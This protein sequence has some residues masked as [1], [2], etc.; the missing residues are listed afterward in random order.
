MALLNASQYGKLGD[1]SSSQQRR[2]PGKFHS[3][4][5]TG[6]SRE[7]QE[8][9][10]FQVMSD[11]DKGIYL[12]QNESEVLF[13]PYFIKRI[14][15]KYTESLNQKNEKYSKLVAFGWADDIPK[16]DDD[17]KY[18]YIIAGLLLDK[19]GQAMKHE[20]DIEDAGIKVGD[21]VLCYFSCGG[22]KFNGAMKFIDHISDK[23]KDLP[24]LSDSPEFERTV[25]YPRRFICKV[26]K[27]I[28]PSKHGDKMVFDFAVATQLPD[29]VVGKVMDS[30]MG[31]LPEFEKQFDKTAFVRGGTASSVSTSVDSDA[32]TFTEAPDPVPESDIVTDDDFD[33]GI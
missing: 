8:I 21:P 15:T 32:P 22:M 20:I 4:F 24:P 30:A 33:L 1:V 27:G 12:K 31:L 11:L 28:A 5:I 14:W 13:I 18:S 9:G 6:A 17:C 25:V 7:G 29:K 3:V 2:T 16:L 19:N 26:M 23:A 10:K